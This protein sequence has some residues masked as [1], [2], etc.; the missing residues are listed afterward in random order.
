[1][2]TNNNGYT[3][4]YTA[5]IVVVVAAVLAFV[6]QSLKKNQEANEQADVISQMMTAAGYG[7]KAGFEALGNANVLAL[8]SEKIVKAYTID[9]VGAVTGELPTAEGEI[10]IY[11]PKQL[12]DIYKG[13]KAGE[14]P[15]ALPVFVFENGATV[16]PIYGAGL[17]G[18]IWGY[19]AFE[20][21]EIKGAYFDH[22][23][24]TAGL[25]ARIKD[26]PEFQARFNGK[27]V[28]VE[29]A[30]QPFEIAKAGFHKLGAD[31]GIDAIAGATMTSNGLNDAINLWLKLYKPFF[32]GATACEGQHHECGEHHACEGHGQEGCEGEHEGCQG[33]H[34][35]CEGHHGDC[36]KPCCQEQTPKAEEE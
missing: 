15:E 10:S 31:N 4:I 27:K 6:S 26:D 35:G 7:E 21:K 8:Y 29:G 22:E 2:N 30:E 24:E 13:A 19:I 32:E 14:A 20:G 36:D 18:P 11:T 23:S 16:I 28:F 1:M 25:G 17:W 34:E 12:K 5:I 33:H 9:A 3:I